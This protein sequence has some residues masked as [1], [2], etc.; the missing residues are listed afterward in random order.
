M[1]AAGGDA[2]ASAGSNSRLTLSGSLSGMG[3]SPLKSPKSPK[4]PKSSSANEAEGKAEGKA[5][6][7]QRS[8]VING[9]M[10]PLNTPQLPN[11]NSKPNSNSNSNSNSNPNPR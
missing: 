8:H 5:E 9:R 11:S 10:Y 2:L 6:G 7:N 3:L 1:L 4:A